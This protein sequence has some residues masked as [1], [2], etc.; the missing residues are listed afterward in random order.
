[1]IGSV[2]FAVTLIMFG[3]AQSHE[4]KLARMK[5]QYPSLV[6]GAVFGLAVLGVYALGSILA[7][8][9]GVTVPVAGMF[10]GTCI[11]PRTPR[12]SQTAF[13]SCVLL[14]L[15]LYCKSLS[16]FLVF[17]GRFIL[18]KLPVTQS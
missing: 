15:L 2:A 3:V 1:M 7:F 6:P 10:N 18:K 16:L 4:P 8:V 17:S 12:G 14:K 13:V 9:S 11:T 5:Q